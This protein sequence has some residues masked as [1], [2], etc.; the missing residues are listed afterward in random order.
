MIKKILAGLVFVLIVCGCAYGLP[1]W[2]ETEVSKRLDLVEVVIAK[3]DLSPRTVIEESYLDTIWVPSVYVEQKAYITKDEVLGKISTSK[4]YIPAGSLFYKSALSNV[5]EVNDAVLFDL[6]EGQVLLALETNLVK[7]AANTLIPNQIVD[8]YVTLEDRERNH[9]FSEL[10]RGVRILG[11]KDHLGLDLEDPKSSGA[12]HVLQLAI[13]KEALPVLQ[14]AIDIGEVSYY[15][16]KDAYLSTSECEIVWDS[17]AMQ[18]LGYEKS[19][20]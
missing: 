4:G 5:S 19:P 15:A 2:V 20:Q 10:L 6:K 8:I 13:T 3:R 17:D 18:L 12:P 9:V 1:Y 16:S 11:V 7:L 14:K